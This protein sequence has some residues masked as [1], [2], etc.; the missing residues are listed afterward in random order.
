MILQ[1]HWDHQV[2]LD[3]VEKLDSKVP[4]AN[5]VNLEHGENL[6]ALAQL[7][8]EDRMVMPDHQVLLVKLDHQGHVEKLDC[9]DLKVRED[10][11]EDQDHKDKEAS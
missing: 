4:K 3:H 8:Q 5:V 11:Q 7:A 6:E 1:D 2:Q 9:L 10:S